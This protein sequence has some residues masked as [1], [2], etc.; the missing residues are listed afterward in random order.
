MKNSNAKKITVIGLLVALSVALIYM[1]RFPIFPVVAFLEYDAGDVPIFLCT[2][3]YGS[4]YGIIIGLIASFIQA[5]TVSASSG[6][7][8]FIMHI[9]AVFGYTVTVGLIYKKKDNTSN[10]IVAAIAGILVMTA[11]MVGWNL[12]FTPIFMN[13][14]RSVVIELL[15]YIILFN[16]IKASI[17]TVVSVILY[18][19]LNQS[20]FNKLIK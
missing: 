4:G 14:P 18:K 17:N 5:I 7:I 19:V 2:Y 11:F 13:V 20:V 15:P 10:L 12:I 1:I 16:L 3:L 6:W 9:F 8:G